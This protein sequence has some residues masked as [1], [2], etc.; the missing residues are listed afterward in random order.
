MLY[1]LRPMSTP[2]VLCMHSWLAALCSFLLVVHF[3]GCLMFKLAARTEQPGVDEVL[4]PEQRY[5]FDLPSTQPTA[6]VHITNPVVHA[7]CASVTI[8]SARCS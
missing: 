4:S 8:A 6:Y 7:C 5:W 3:V 2:V 1:F